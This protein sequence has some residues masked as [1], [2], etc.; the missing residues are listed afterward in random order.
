[1][2]V[3]TATPEA[4]STDGERWRTQAPA[5][6]L[7]PAGLKGLVAAALLAALMSTVSGA[8]NSAATLFSYD[9]YA[10]WF[11]RTASEAKL[12]RVGR[13]VTLVGMA[14]AIAWSPPKTR[15]R[16]RSGAITPVVLPGEVQ[17]V[18]ET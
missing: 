4:A 16:H 8:L 14:L 3:S 7:L 10:R 5:P 17:A 2:S 12:V 11:D 18:R 15:R 1:M 13:V 9:L 6:Q